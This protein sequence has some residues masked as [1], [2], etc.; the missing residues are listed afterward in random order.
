MDKNGCASSDKVGDLVELYLESIRCHQ[1]YGHVQ[2]IHRVFKD[3]IS[4]R[5]SR[6]LTVDCKDAEV[7]STV[8]DAVFD[9]IAMSSVEEN[10]QPRL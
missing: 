7:E 10:G 4:V 5:S 8:N 1:I 9:G 6:I 3:F 2:S